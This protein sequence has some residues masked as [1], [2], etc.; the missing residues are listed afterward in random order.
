MGAGGGRMREGDLLGVRR[1]K[2]SITET[3]I[4]DGKDGKGVFR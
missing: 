4:C 1:V 2:E 3:P